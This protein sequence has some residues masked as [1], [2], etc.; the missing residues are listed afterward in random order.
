MPG[1]KPSEKSALTPVPS[2]GEALKRLAPAYFP[3]HPA[4][5]SRRR[6]AADC[7]TLTGST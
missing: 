6:L 4:F 3:H 2:R 1:A 7:M 5:V